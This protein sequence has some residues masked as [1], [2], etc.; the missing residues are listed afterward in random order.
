MLQR[1]VG[2]ESQRAALLA[3]DA[4]RTRRD[5]RSPARRHLRQSLSEALYRVTQGSRLMGSCTSQHVA[6]ESRTAWRALQSLAGSQ[7]SV[8]LHVAA[9][10]ARTT[11]QEDGEETR[12]P[13]PIDRSP[14]TLRGCRRRALHQVACATLLVLAVP[15]K[16]RG[17][18]ESPQIARIAMQELPTIPR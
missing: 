5:T 8:R 4:Q 6:L 18:A 15:P 14:K 9:L 17:H 7:Q 1:V 10:V 2:R 13:L 11:V 12:G 3:R 16:D